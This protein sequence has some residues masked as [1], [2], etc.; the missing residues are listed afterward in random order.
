MPLPIILGAVAATAGVIGVG[1][2][3]HGASKM[4]D[5]SDTIEAAENRHK[6]NTAKFE[7]ISEMTSKKMD[8]LGTL[9]LTILKEFDMFSNTI[10][11]IQNR[12]QF[13]KY[14]R[15]DITL[16][17]YDKEE[18]EK[19]SIGA[20][21]I[22]GAL[23]GAALGTAGGF[24]AA[25]AT[26][27]AVTTF[28]TASTG[29]VISALKGEAAK[30]AVL[31]A[32]GGGSIKVGG[33]GIALGTKILSTT[34]LGLGLMVGGILFSLKG[35]SMSEKADATYEEMKKAEKTIETIC[36]YL[37]ELQDTAEEYIESLKRIKN[38][39]YKWF[40]WLSFTVN[41]GNKTDWNLFTKE[42]KIATENT[43]LLVGLLY[44][45]CQVNIVEKA[46][47]ENEMNTINKTEIEKTMNNA[48]QIEKELM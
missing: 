8:E 4:K 36:T 29:T 40:A 41:Q 1:T 31:A 16:P 33:G 13:Q 32:L 23:G 12:P 38:L 34:S 44:K 26:T 19:V 6:S 42:E 11:K 48:K 24:A 18:L 10:E 17:K 35:E 9:E 47:N 21:V 22:L 15:T 43:V 14:Q 45:M 7:M 30:K 37:S 46:K 5:A 20:G 25:G 27:S 39:Y 3:L 2:G 28:G